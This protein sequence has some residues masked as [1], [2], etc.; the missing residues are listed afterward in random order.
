MKQMFV[1]QIQHV[2]S[3][4]HHYFHFSHT[5]DA[6]SLYNCPSIQAKIIYHATSRLIC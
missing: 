3:S 1:L 5:L 4:V 6:H 2:Q